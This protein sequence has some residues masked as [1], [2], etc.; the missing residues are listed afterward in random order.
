MTQN[1]RCPNTKNDVTRKKESEENET[2]NFVNE[3]TTVIK[4]I[5]TIFYKQR[6]HT[7]QHY[8]YCIYQITYLCKAKDRIVL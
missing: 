7:T 8:H 4:K 3:K 6:K 5:I 2:D 1:R